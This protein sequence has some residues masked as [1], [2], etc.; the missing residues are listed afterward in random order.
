MVTSCGE[1]A[2]LALVH[3]MPANSVLVRGTVVAAPGGLLFGFDAAVIAGATQ[4]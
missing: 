3:T 4:P 2:W 1:Q